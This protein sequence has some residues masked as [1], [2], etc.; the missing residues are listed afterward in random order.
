MCRMQLE[1]ARLEQENAL[2]VAQPPNSS[3]QPSLCAS[4]QSCEQLS[5]YCSM[6]A[7][8][9]QLLGWG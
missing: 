5:E 6:L 3:S 8:R 2:K 4:M 1:I 9:Q 7:A